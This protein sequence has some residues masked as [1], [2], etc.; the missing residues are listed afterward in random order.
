MTVNHFR[1]LFSDELS[2]RFDEVSQPPVEPAAVMAYLSG[3]SSS[4]SPAD[5]RG[6][7]TNT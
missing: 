4:L 3:I 1:G 7:I 6:A 5:I 2:K